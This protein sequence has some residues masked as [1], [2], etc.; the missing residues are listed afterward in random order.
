MDQVKISYD[1][2][3]HKLDEKRKILDA[4]SKTIKHL[5]N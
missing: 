2:K 4:T 5:A 3:F 1:R